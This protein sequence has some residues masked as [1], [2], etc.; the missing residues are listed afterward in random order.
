MEVSAVYCDG[1]RH[2]GSHG[3][4]LSRRRHLQHQP[5]DHHYRRHDRCNHLLH[6]RQFNAFSCERRLHPWDDL[7]R[8]DHCG[9]DR[10]DGASHRHAQRRNQQRRRFG[11]LHPASRRAHTHSARRRL[12]RPTVGNSR[13]HHGRL[14]DLLHH[15]RQHAHRDGAFDPLQRN[16]H[17]RHRERNHHQRHHHR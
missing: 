15:R 4:D 14:A 2:H 3:G 5:D 16:A 10:H 1:N 13:N 11:H 9:A 7:Q 8:S 6:D 12:L 17:L